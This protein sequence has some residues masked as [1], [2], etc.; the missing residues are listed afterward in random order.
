MSLADIRAKLLAQ[1]TRNQQNTERTQGDRANYPF[2]NMQEGQSATVRFLP[3]G[4][5]NNSFFWVERS[6][7]KLPFMG[8]KGQSQD[9][10]FIV[11]VPCM[12]MY[13]VACPILAEVRTWY[14]DESLKET[15]NK[16]WKKRTYLFQGFVRQNPLADDTTPENPIRRF[17][18]SPQVFA[19]I[20]SSLMNP[21][22]ETLPTDFALGLD[23]KLNKTSK[24]GYADY[25]T[26]NWARKETALLDSERAAI[27]AYGLFNLRE[28]LPKQPSE[29]EQRVIREM[30]EAS[31]DGRPYDP[32]RWGGYYRPW[33]MKVD[34]SS[35]GSTGGDDVE[36]DAPRVQVSVPARPAA[37]VTQVT[38]VQESVKPVATDTTDTPPWE[39]DAQAAADSLAPRAEVKSRTS[40][41]AND[42]LAL[43]R[44]RQKTA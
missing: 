19:I 34:G 5:P 24:G 32:D 38:H 25:S 12:E 2:W 44:A 21:E 30:F 29:A 43:I 37:Q 26:S 7:F 8:V 40:D 16:Y 18:I 20:K 31:V 11:Q 14:K 9:R 17:M 6:M 22:I 4:D 27:E 3:D 10:Q 35:Q 1:D 41:K 42:I 13:G 33:G 15:A 23:F 36:S 39:D 28:N